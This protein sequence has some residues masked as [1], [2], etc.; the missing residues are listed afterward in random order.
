M[1]SMLAE[2][3]PCRTRRES[4]SEEEGEMAEG[5]GPGDSGLTSRRALI[6][7]GA[8]VV[9]GGAAAIVAVATGGNDDQE[10]TNAAAGSGYPRR[11]IAAVSDIKPN[12]PVN[13]DYPGKGQTSVLLDLGGE[14]PGGVG[15]NKS[16]VAYSSLCQHMGCPVGYQAEQKHF[17]C[18]C[19]QTRYDPAREGVVI[20]GVAQRG[21][22]RVGLEIDGD[23]VFA[24]GVQG[25]IYGYR[26]NL[27]NATQ[28][29]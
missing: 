6:G 28:G 24:V 23:D 25:L 17:T 18:G 16:I 3:V 5:D 15:D 27:A 12:T 20:Q 22:P 7:G 26:T 9:V 29:G 11:R 19:H 2:F 13:F 4:E 10:T 1:F 14:V 21:L 8:L